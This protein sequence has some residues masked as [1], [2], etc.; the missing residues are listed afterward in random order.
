MLKTQQM[1]SLFPVTHITPS[2]EPHIYA[3]VGLPATGKSTYARQLRLKLEKEGKNAVI[4]SRDAL[5][6]QLYGYDDSNLSLY[7]L[8]DSQEMFKRMKRISEF[9]DNMIYDALSRGYKVIL[10]SSHLEYKNIKKL[11][12]W[13]VPVE[14]VI[15]EVDKKNFK[16]IKGLD[17]NREKGIGED[18]LKRLF[19]RYNFTRQKLKDEPFDFTPIEKP[20]YDVMKDNCIIFD[21]DGTLAHNNCGRRFNDMTRTGEDS[22]HNDICSILELI[23]RGRNDNTYKT[24]LNRQKNPR[25]IFC[26]GRSEQAKEDTLNWISKI[27]NVHTSDLYMREDG[28]KREDWKVKQEMWAKLE[29][30]YNIIAMFDDR[31]QVVRRARALGYRVLQVSQN[32]F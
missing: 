27:Y 24:M 26:S 20:S 6:K 29:E 1:N 28:D 21:L 15:I 11:K 31:S 2:D 17:D 25:I 3:M 18:K 14:L 32:N 13:N 12:Y 10:D 5:R 9:E 22:Y 7:Y 23:S 16:T 4:V 19:D 30:N 8:N